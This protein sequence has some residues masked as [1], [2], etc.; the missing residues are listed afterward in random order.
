MR[1][2]DS[3]VNCG[4]VALANALEA[5]GHARSVDELVKLCKTSATNGTSPRNLVRAIEHLKES[6]DLRDHEIIKTGDP[7]AAWGLLVHGL[8]Q[9]HASV[10]LVDDAQHYVS[11]VGLLGESVLVVDSGDSEVLVTY[12]REEWLER[13]DS[14]GRFGYWA[15]IL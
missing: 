1:L 4:P 9:G 15:I 3:K 10:G 11:C 13:W 2:Q 8:S 7:M 5:M 6:C 14:G 12:T